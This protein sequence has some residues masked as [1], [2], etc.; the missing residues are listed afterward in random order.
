MAKEYFTVQDVPKEIYWKMLG[1]SIPIECKDKVDIKDFQYLKIFHLG[2][3]NKV[4]IGEM[5]VNKK[6]S[7]EVLEIFKKL[8]EINYKIEKMKLIDEY[9]ADDELSMADNNT[10]CFCYRKIVGKNK[11]SYHAMGTAID[12]NPLYNPCVQENNISPA[13]AVIYADRKVENE[14]KISKNDVLYNLFTSFGWNWGGELPDK[15]DYQHFYKI[16]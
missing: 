15:I 12:I 14:Y 11:L 13:N 4:H 7:C 5:I 1:K 3:D 8:Y 10:S 16:L 6:I 9:N 2:F